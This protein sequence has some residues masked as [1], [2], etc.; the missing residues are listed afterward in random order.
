MQKSSLK[1]WQTREFRSI[2]T[3]GVQRAQSVGTT[4]LYVDPQ[5]I[6]DI[7]PMKTAA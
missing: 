1:Q 4:K 5:N 7:P 2:V 6:F 3:S